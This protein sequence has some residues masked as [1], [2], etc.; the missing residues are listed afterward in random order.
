MAKEQPAKAGQSPSGGHGW[1]GQVSGK[2]DREVREMRNAETVLGIIRERGRKGLPLERV[3]RLLFNRDLFVYAYG[4][5]AQNK[6]A[7]TPGAT[8]ETADGMSL[9]KIEVI[10]DVLR[11]ERYQWMPARRVYIEKK[12]STKKRPLGLPTWSDKLVQE[13]MR[14]ILEAYYEPQF[15]EHSHGFRRDRG[16]HTALWEIQRCWKGTGWFIE[17]DISQCF[18]K[19]S[20]DV[21]HDILA[22]NIHD[23]RFV[24]L[25]DELLKAGYLEEWRFN[26]TLSGTPQ[27]G[28]VSPILANIYLDRFDQW[29]EQTVLPHHNR[30]DKRQENPAYLK[31]R[32]KAVW[33]ET[34]GHY[35]EAHRL[36]RHM[37]TLPSK[38]PN[39]PRY[40]RLRYVR[41]ADDFL[42]GFIGPHSEA[43]EI[44]REIGTF[45]HDT[46]H[47]ELSET[48]TLITHAR[49][50][51][52]HFL[53]YE[54]HTIRNDTKL[55]KA[56]QRQINGVIG[57]KVPVV[58][59]RSKCTP[60]L[61][62]G[63]PKHRTERVDDS[64]FSIIAAYQ[65]E[66]RGIVEYYRLAYNLHRLDRLKWVMEQSLTK[67]LAAKLHIT[68]SQVYKR[69]RTT[70]HTPQGDYQGL[71]VIV[72]REGEGR[73]PL[74]AKWG[75]ISLKRDIHTELDDAPPRAWLTRTQLEQRLLADTC[76]VCASHDRVQVHHVRAMRDLQKRGRK[77]K[78]EGEKLMIARH[79]KTV[80]LCHTCH[81]D[82]EYGRPR[83]RHHTEHTDTGEPDLSKG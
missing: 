24:R 56:G 36:R 33:H 5:I 46:L 51:V 29:V 62:H 42:L 55:T 69:Y 80:V 18:D 16:C 38:R 21:L 34:K 41:Y 13:V 15:S 76:E 75:G 11:H 8:D 45:L 60:Y 30:G 83:R 63:M 1:A 49:S 64:V 61:S 74:I 22:E 39:D 26:R 81:M 35:E 40:R 57:L 14:L 27:G 31:L 72:E 73:K 52:A 68:V 25:I 78:S 67:T 23:G 17:G 79:R 50:D 10:M 54:M 70:L 77:P 65:L 6:G 59:I 9:A 48:K 66:Y 19:L 3:Y 53:G 12:N 7:M 47:L 71:H 82:V 4:R 44:K 43:E 28:V 58:V 2:P 32:N 37:Q 20:H